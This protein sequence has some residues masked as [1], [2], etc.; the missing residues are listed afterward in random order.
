[1][2]K[3]SPFLIQ[4]FEEKLSRSRVEDDEEIQAAKSKV[5]DLFGKKPKT[6]LQEK[7]KPPAGRPKE[8]ILDPKYKKTERG[9]HQL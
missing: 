9:M 8:F 5:A 3:A 1:M 6:S 7:E 4:T 2:V